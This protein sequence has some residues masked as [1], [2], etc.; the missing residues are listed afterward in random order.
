[1]TKSVTKL[2]QSH[3]VW[4]SHRASYPALRICDEIW[5]FVIDTLWSMTKS[6]NVMRISSWIKGFLV[7]IKQNWSK[8]GVNKT[9]AEHYSGVLL[10]SLCTHVVHSATCITLFSLVSLRD[11]T[12][13]P[14]L[15]AMLTLYWSVGGIPLRAGIYIMPNLSTLKAGSTSRGASPHWGDNWRHLTIP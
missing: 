5:L 12:L 14:H 11:L 13:I 2:A 4:T 7:V 8:G 15:L 10:S 1:V 6:K 9:H 3:S